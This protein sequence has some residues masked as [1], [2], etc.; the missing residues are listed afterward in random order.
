MFAVIQF[1]GSNDDRDMRF[2][3]KSV[4]GVAAELVWH[5]NPELPPGT[6]GVLL[7]GGFSYGDY[8]RCGA[9]ARFSPVMTAVRRFAEAG[10]PVLGTC[11]GF[12]VLCEA[13]LLPGALLRNRDLDFLCDWIHVRVEHAG[14]PF[15]SRARAGQVLRLPIKHGEGRYAI[16]ADALAGLE[17]GGQVLLRYCTPAGAVDETANPNGSIG[18]IAGV[19]NAAG[20]VMGLM[21]HPE[22]AV[23]ALTGGTDGLALLGSLVDAVTAAGRS[24]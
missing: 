19:R 10:G 21:P 9:M 15:L 14:A 3:M 5:K 16:A 1:P 18:N 8:L 22:H 13:G 17:A 23:E 24:R 7:P 4:L 6:A 20:N 12:Q 11:N 2:A